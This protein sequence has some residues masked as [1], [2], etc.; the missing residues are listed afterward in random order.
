MN[1]TTP[2]APA[3]L[4]D[5]Q[6]A[7]QELAA[8]FASLGITAEITGAHAA[9]DPAEGHD[10]KGW[11]HVAVTVTFTRRPG[12]NGHGRPVHAAVSYS[13]PYSMGVGLADWPAILKRTHVSSDDYP[14]IKAMMG[15]GRLSPAAQIA[16]CSK[17]LPAFVKRVNPAEVLANCCRDGQDATGQSFE[18]WASEYGYD[19]DSRKAESVYRACQAAGD[20]VARLLS[21][22]RGAVAKLAELSSQL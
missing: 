1:Q 21:H 7:A 18:S 4:P 22:E 19:T 8:Y 15:Q 12:D 16:L 5:Y 13:T 3:S 6:A 11:A 10:G 14:L 17:H 9:I 2:D 20:G